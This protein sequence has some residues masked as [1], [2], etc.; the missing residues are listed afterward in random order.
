MP[1]GAIVIPARYQSSRFP[2]K[3]LADILGRPM[4]QHVYDKCCQAIDPSYV[5]VATDSHQI[6]S[7]VQSFNG[8]VIMTSSD[9]LTGT[10]RLAEANDYLNQEFLINVQGDEPMIDPASISSAYNYMAN[11]S[12]QV[13]NC[14]SKIENNEIDM[15][16]VPKVVI[17]ESGRLLYMSRG[18]C[19]FDKEGNPQAKYKQVCIYGFNRK[20]LS[21]F[22]E[23][24]SKSINEETEDIEILRF[25]DLDVSVQMLEV[26]GRT[27]AVDT[28][29][30]LERV[31]K[32]LSV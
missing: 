20:H 16:T 21:I 22:R 2:G 1:K 24:S 14:Y 12:S 28:P 18:G 15:E 10:D 3:P 29:E 19:P 11:D 6:K 31:K 5:Y 30:D 17:S 4:I 8:K 9:C 25:L 7:V 27:I 26:S 23:R 13:L 32:C